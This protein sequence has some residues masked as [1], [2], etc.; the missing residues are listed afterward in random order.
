MTK[1]IEEIQNLEKGERSCLEVKGL[2]KILAN[3][4][5]VLQLSPGL[6]CTKWIDIP[7]S[8][9]CEEPQPRIL[10]I[11]SC[12]DHTHPYVQL[13]LKRPNDEQEKIFF[14]LAEALIHDDKA[15]LETSQGYFSKASLHPSLPPSQQLANY[16]EDAL[17]YAC[18]PCHDEYSGR[19]LGACNNGGEIYYYNINR[20]VPHQQAIRNCHVYCDNQYWR[21]GNRELYRP[22]L[23]GCDHC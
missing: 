5:T 1:F 12:K 19:S 4:S 10:K 11:Q 21:T 18:G 17:F 8:M 2:V 23:Y 3:D 9:I 22:C 7:T 16:H 14:S 13:W 6:T 20:G 15:H